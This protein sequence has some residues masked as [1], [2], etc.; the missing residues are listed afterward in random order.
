MVFIIYRSTN[1]LL[2]SSCSFV[3]HLTQQVL[4]QQL[5]GERERRVKNIK[6]MSEAL[7]RAREVRSWQAQSRV[8]ER[9]DDALCLCN[10]AVSRYTRQHDVPQDS[11]PYFLELPCCSCCCVLQPTQVPLII[12][13]STRGSMHFGDVTARLVPA[14]T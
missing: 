14:M 4:Q 6:S 13:N 1:A 9:H 7:Q 12:P 11:I 8:A 2:S 10:R 5:T 3:S